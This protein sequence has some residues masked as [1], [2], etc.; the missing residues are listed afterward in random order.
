M[1]ITNNNQNKTFTTSI[2]GDI[3]SDGKIDIADLLKVQK[4]IKNASKLSGV[5]LS[6]A[7]INKDSIVDIGDLLKVQ[8]HI[9]GVSKIVR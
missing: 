9:K 8:K 5:Y 6:S 1:T 4:H 7:D 2:T 3:N